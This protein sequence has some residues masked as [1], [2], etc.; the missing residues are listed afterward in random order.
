M[1]TNSQYRLLVENLRLIAA[2]AEVQLEVL[3]QFVVAT[4]E[5]L[6]G[7]SDAFL[8]VPQLERVGLVQPSARVA[9]SRLDSWFDG[10]PTDGSIA[11]PSTLVSHGFWA[12]ARELA[13]DA[14]HALGEEVR[15][16]SLDQTAWVKGGSS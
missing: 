16:P 6:S 12:R 15:Q 10:M 7:F 9:L 8:L 5:I 3:P 13:A 14:L 1:D 2:P 11:E 4:D